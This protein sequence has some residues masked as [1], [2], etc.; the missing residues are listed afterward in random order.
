MMAQPTQP[1]PGDLDVEVSE[2]LDALSAIF[3]AEHVV[4]TIERAGA[5]GGDGRGGGDGEVD[6]DRERAVASHSQHSADA[7]IPATANSLRSA[8]RDQGS[9]EAKN[10]SNVRM[11]VRCG[12]GKRYELR[13]WLPSGYPLTR[14]I[15]SVG[16]VREYGVSVDDDAITQALHEWMAESPHTEAAVL[17]ELIS[18]VEDYITAH[19][20][21]HETA[22]SPSTGPASTEEGAACGGGPQGMPSLGA[23]ASTAPRPPTGSLEESD[24]AV[25]IDNAGSAHGTK[26]TLASLASKR[27]LDGA[28]TSPLRTS[29]AHTLHSAAG[30]QSRGKHSARGGSV[31]HGQ[32][33]TGQAQPPMDTLDRQWIWFIGFYTKSIIKAFCST[34]AELGCTGFLMPGK[35]AV[36]AVE[37]T[38][39]A[40]AEFLRVTRTELFARVPP[41]SRKMKLCLVDRGIEARVFTGFEERTLRV[42]PGAH[43][44]KDIADLGGLEAFLRDRGLSHAFNEIFDSAVK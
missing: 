38:P 6:D 27:S 24:I 2:E 19:C 3:G 15:V 14:P 30:D 8:L 42:V 4:V 5:S 23:C 9:D 39:S 7:N 17:F 26:D 32:A 43:K 18:W 35:P 20:D 34:A 1:R 44:R 29:A 13:A 40:I 22:S 31:R 21:S 37:G 33:T 28:S 11:R 16:Q 25:P 12:P 10:L 41:A 36:A